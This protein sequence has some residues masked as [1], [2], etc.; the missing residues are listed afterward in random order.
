MDSNS[1]FL[2]HNLAIED[3]QNL[4][5]F[6]AGNKSALD[7]TLVRRALWDYTIRIQEEDYA[8]AEHLRNFIRDIEQEPSIVFDVD[9][10]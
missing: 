4:F 8:F 9:D 7:D 1:S 2:Q 10:R 6:L 5:N 3:K